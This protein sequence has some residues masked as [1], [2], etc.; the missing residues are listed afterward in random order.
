MAEAL[1]VAS[2]HE[3][4]HGSPPIQRVAVVGRDEELVRLERGLKRAFAGTGSVFM[5]SGEAGI[6]KSRLIEE[7]LTCA[8]DRGARIL[9]GR[10]SEAV[11]TPAFWVWTQVLR[12]VLTQ[13][14]DVDLTR[15]PG[16]TAH[17]LSSLS[18]HIRRLLTVP[19]DEIHDEPADRFSLFDAARNL[20]RSF[21]G[22]RATVL[23][24][25]DLH[26]VDTSSLQLLRFITDEHLDWPVVI[27]CS[28]DDV[29]VRRSRERARLLASVAR[30]AERIELSALSQSDVA[31][32]YRSTTGKELND[33]LAS[34][35]F[36]AT[37][38]NPLFVKEAM[39][40]L[41]SRGGI[42]RPDYSHGF[43]VPEG[44]RGL[45]R[46][47]LDEL[48][49]EVTGL[50]SIAS[51]IGREFDITVLAA[52]SKIAVEDLLAIL[53]EAL[54]AAILVET[55]ALGRYEFTHI[56]I[57][58]T[59]YEDLTPGE[60][61]RLH[62]GV[63]EI[64]EGSFTDDQDPRLSEVAHHWF[65]A[66]QAGDP[67]KAMALALRAAEVARSQRA[68]EEAIRLYQRAIMVAPAAAA[69]R[70][71]IEEIKQGLAEVQRLVG[72]DVPTEDITPHVNVFRKEGDYW[73]ISF[74]GKTSRLKDVRGLGYI[75]QLL[76]NP[77]QEIHSLDLVLANARS[78]TARTV[79]RE[80][81][82]HRW[83]GGDAGPI[84]DGA[85]KS[86]YRR[87][88]E[89]LEAELNEARE[90]NDPERAARAQAEIDAIVAELNAA[91]G[92]GGR[93]RAVAAP[94]ERARINVTKAVKAVL[95]RI[96]T[97]DPALA[98]HLRATVRTGAFCS[99]SPDPR[100][101]VRW[102]MGRVS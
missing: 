21:A 92:L 7:F 10:C 66:A 5:I 40:L 6:G 25:E 78:S 38:G 29:S 14:D 35:L 72:P 86:Q 99:Y 82:L 9:R 36:K 62:R 50:L 59:L 18:P 2:P 68:Y 33:E 43:R 55:S 98:R 47:R 53:D 69:D 37:Q 84:L 30:D 4:G 80:E 19:S 49:D 75:A 28:Y 73:S 60:R 42:R 56:L 1:A 96:A 46:A 94:A 24:L 34:T 91:L 70:R 8:G 77:G 11:D 93:D 45:I 39:K 81:G 67:G 57:R 85:A 3:G 27:V 102:E 87:R 52:V 64:I 15:L 95:A 88:L 76:K 48:S 20:L 51:V 89:D 63:A 12:T 54:S 16:E 13:L 23:V 44:I 83:S 58:E 74:E 22:E 100:V 101:P 31:L 79:A 26:A 41:D 71:V 90:F 17:E 65:K 32:L 61:M 97:H